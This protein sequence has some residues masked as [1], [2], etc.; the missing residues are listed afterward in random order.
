MRALLFPALVFLLSRSL[1]AAEPEVAP[2][3]LP[4][5]APTPPDRALATLTVRA[6]FRAEQMAAEPLVEDPI[7]MAFDEDGKLFVIEM[8]D[9]SERRDEKLGRVKLLEDTD[10]D[11][12]YDKA[13]IFTEGLPWPTAVTCW[14]GG[15]F[16]IASPDLLYFKDT[17]GDRRADVHAQV[18]TGFGSLAEKLNVQALPNSL[19]WG[20]DQRIHGALG[21][22]PSALKN[23]AR[24]SDPPLQLRD[25]DFSFDPRDLALRAE[26]G[27]GQFGMSF[28]DAGRKFVCSN[29]RH[30]IQVM[31]G[32]SVSSTAL[33]L[34]PPGV[35]I[36]RDGPQAEVFRTSPIEAWRILRTEWRVTGK[37]RGL[38]E[39]GG[40]PGGYFTSA[41]GITI[42]R[43]DGF[44]AEFY[45]DAFVADSGSNL[46]HRKKLSGG[47]QLTAVRAPGE[48]KSEFLTSTDNWFRPVAFVNAPDGCL[49]VCDMYREVI[50]H[51]WSM[52]ANIKARLD[53]NAGNDRGRL[54]RI[55]PDGYKPRAQ[56]KL[57]GLRAEELV[58][59][60]AHPNGWHRD[61][62]ARLLHQ[63]QDKAAPP[64]LVKLAAESPSAIGRSTA[65][66][67]L[68]GLE[69][70]DEA[71]L[72]KALADKDPGVRKEGV[73][74][75]A[76]LPGTPLSP[77]LETA[78]T[79]LATDESASVRYELSWALGAL[80]STGRVTLLA[81][82]LN[83]AD[84]PWLQSAALAAAGDQH[85]AVL[86]KLAASNAPRAA[87][88]RKMVAAP[89]KTAAPL[90][91][92]APAGSRAEAVATFAP[93]LALPGN[94]AKGAKTFET[95]CAMCH[96]LA[97]RGSAV[98]PDLDAARA[99]G[100]EKVLGNILEPSREITAGFPLG[101]VQTKGGETFSGVIANDTG[102]SLTLRLP[103]GVAHPLRS[104]DITK[105]ERPPRSL[106]PD[107]LE[108]GLTPQDMADLLEFLTVPP[109]RTSL[110]EFQTIG[111]WQER[112]RA[113]LQN[114]QAIMGPLP[115][116]EKRIP[117][118]V[119]V[120]EET[121]CGAYVRRLLTYASEP[122][123]R[124]PAYLLIPKT[125]LANGATPVSAVLCPHPTDNR[126]GH[127][128]VV[129]LGGKPNRAYAAEL[130]E[131]G[132]VTIAP[133]YPLLANYQPDLA[134]L[135]YASGT[136][137]AIW[138]NIRALDLLESLPF[139]Q[140]SGF[141]AIGHSLGGH[142]S[143][144]TAAFDE[145]IKAVVSSC[146]LDSFR[147]YKGGDITGWTSTRYMPRLTEYV[148]RVHEM[149]F[150]FDEVLAA[151]A[152]RGVFISAPV[153][154]DNFRADSVDRIAAIAREV[155]ALHKVP[156]QIV[157]QHPDCA[158][159]F[160]DEIRKNSY[161]WLAQRLK[162]NP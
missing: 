30:I 107:G 8:R 6:G 32:A 29:S 12:R 139:V 100:R 3:D 63:R 72:I 99:S 120:S 51:P 113:I 145:R 39:G 82:L 7:A 155:F 148:G 115:G 96:R 161:E 22:N 50:E 14:D 90:P 81:A 74:L 142:N 112:R 109:R 84:H 137:K 20:P 144:F 9:Y 23:F 121:D 114:M 92:L 110:G 28:D 156:D 97:G 88:L 49:W 25:R 118:D 55:A 141:G 143:V 67:V 24:S 42:Y 66:R 71:T 13:S 140:H 57:S 123:S 34:P 125:A 73:R 85:E 101:I 132:F 52:P 10:G 133:A 68:G 75:L 152:P 38:I 17:D 47:V 93:S 106:M 21:G 43:G 91:V 147:D 98:G 122:G 2:E 79:L 77:T 127:K 26:T 15:I 83:A 87:E 94:P 27:G 31:Y 69:A 59:L 103:G 149:P 130:A 18:A 70:F 159:D 19:Q 65:L 158:H 136:M 102:D 131:R 129:G 76:K 64:A 89:T 54:W 41:S 138:D 116:A 78:L 105:I 95:R 45:G 62:A 162:P 135:G 61:T 40:R 146:G 111:E 60:L 151:I 46:I 56:P 157:V 48:E 44:P 37:V 117:L 58:A 126:I 80:N 16:V 35:D 160:P 108:A 150:D 104:G 4:R 5:L 134:A 154:D 119:Q 86:G 36:A 153:R 33:P 11:G 128:V 53:L 1:I 124:V